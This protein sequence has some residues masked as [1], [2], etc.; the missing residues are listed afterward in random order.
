MA[1]KSQKVSVDYINLNRFQKYRDIKLTQSNHLK[2]LNLQIAFKVWPAWGNT[3]TK[4][5]K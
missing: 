4:Q 3:N 2:R 5:S 1:A